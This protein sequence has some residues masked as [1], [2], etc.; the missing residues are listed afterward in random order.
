MILDANSVG[1]GTRLKADVCIVGAGA[2]GISLA[3]SLTGKGL[4]IVLL[5]SGQVDLHVVA[6]GLVASGRTDPGAVRP[7]QSKLA[8]VVAQSRDGEAAD[9]DASGC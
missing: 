7:L 2:A 3:L 8:E 6:S 9:D 4:D 5:E 1:N